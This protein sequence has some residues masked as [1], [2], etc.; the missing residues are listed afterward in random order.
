MLKAVEGLILVCEK[1]HVFINVDTGVGDVNAAPNHGICVFQL[2]G[3]HGRRVC[4][5]F[6]GFMPS[7]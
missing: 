5:C 4:V 7:L 1:V 3:I 2:R 6:C